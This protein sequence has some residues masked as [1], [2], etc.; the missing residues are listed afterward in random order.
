MDCR[1][2]RAKNPSQKRR[3][4]TPTVR[5]P[6][7][8]A[9]WRMLKCSVRAKER[10]NHFASF[11]PLPLAGLSTS[12]A[13]NTFRANGSHTQQSVGERDRPRKCRSNRANDFGQAD[14]L[15]KAGYWLALLIIAAMVM[16]SFIL[17]QQMMAASGT[18]IRC[19]IWSARKRR[20]RSA[21]CSSPTRPTPL[22]EPATGT[23]HRTQTGDGR[24]REELRPSARA[25]GRRPGVTGKARSKIGRE[26]AFRQAV[27]SRLFLGR[28]GRQWRTPGFGG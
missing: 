15:I 6:Q 5:W 27:S 25:G 4:V 8:A 7:N 22:D 26:R 23:G 12:G 16:A 20:C 21:L 18:T 17:L 11:P 2:A 9:K 1:P 3:S 14:L 24:I 28:S 10:D 13:V 19:S